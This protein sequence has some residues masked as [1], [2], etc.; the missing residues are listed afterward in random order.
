MTKSTLGRG[1]SSLIPPSREA[2]ESAGSS[3][4]HATGERVKKVSTN[5]IKP[6]PRQPRTDFD[7]GSLEELIESI[8]VHG[9]I[10]PLIVQ[11]NKEGYQLIA[12][13]RRL[14]AAKVAGMSSVPVVI[15]SSSDQENLEIALVENVQ[16]QNLNPI[17]RAFGYQMLVDEFNLTQEAVAKKVGQSRA[18]VANTLRLLSLPKKM[19]DALSAGKITEGHAK[20]LMSVE[21]ESERERLFKDIVQNKLNVRIAEARAKKVSVRKHTRKTSQKDPN[22]QVKVDALQE[23]LG[24]RVDIDRKGEQGAI[25]IHFYS[26]EELQDIIR[27]ITS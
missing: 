2:G 27:K 26:N 10:Q 17:E 14:R 5:D 8:K 20:A 15:R 6:N 22:M 24:T 13:E 11:Q 21:S 12:G 19:Q 9:I 1:L 4:V 18:A 3:T 25:T 16:R 7:R 23:A